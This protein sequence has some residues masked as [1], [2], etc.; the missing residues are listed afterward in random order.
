MVCVIGMRVTGCARGRGGI[1][2]M[3]GWVFWLVTVGVQF[4]V[5]REQYSSQVSCWGREAH[6]KQWAQLILRH[7]DG[8]GD[9]VVDG[10]DVD[11]SD[12]DSDCILGPKLEV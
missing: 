3:G 12:G 9:C 2:G 8:D 1:G 10:N 4:G 11:V 7:S 6:L 5:Q